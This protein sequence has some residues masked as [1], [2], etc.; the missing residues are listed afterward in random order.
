VLTGLIAA[1]RAMHFA[2]A[3][4]LFGQFVYAGAV[5]PERRAPLPSPRVAVVALVL[6]LASALAWIALEA[7]AMSGLP[8]AQAL[9]ADTLGIVA[10]QTLFGQVWIA[11]MVLAVALIVV[12]LYRRAHVAAALLAALVLATIALSGHAVGDKG[13][14]RVVHVCADALHL[15]AAGAWL[16]ALL[17]L[18]AML[19]RASDATLAAQAT[20][21]FST[22]GIA[23]MASLFLSG[24]INA[25]YIVAEPM[26]LLHSGY[27]RLLLAKI[28]LFFL[29]LAL[30]SVNRAVLMPRLALRQLRRIAIAECLLGFA[31]IAIVGKLGITIPGPHHP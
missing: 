15:L 8:L 22:L 10:T 14:D 29:V 31:V 21:R 17:P 18:V 11:R 7:L 2:A 20:Q 25:Y 28:V 13:V 27:G 26:A 3:I 5:A 9:S 4:V 16:G 1:V 12:L 19:G 30:A 23:C 6:L 24:I